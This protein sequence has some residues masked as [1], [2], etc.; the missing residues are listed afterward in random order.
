MALIII[1]HFGRRWNKIIRSGKKCKTNKKKKRKENGNRK[2]NSHQYQLLN[3]RS[4][5]T[6][7]TFHIQ[8]SNYTSIKFSALKVSS[9]AQGC[10]MRLLINLSISFMTLDDLN[11]SVL[12]YHILQFFAR[13]SS[14]NLYLQ[15][16]VWNL[17][18]SLDCFRETIVNFPKIL[19]RM[20]IF[21]LDDK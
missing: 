20:M 14:H 8:M 16:A 6:V 12:V 21:N 5:N 17:K 13:Y 11:F 10:P 3:S 19:M 9:K 2:N 15:L 18:L 4:Y 7:F 1:V